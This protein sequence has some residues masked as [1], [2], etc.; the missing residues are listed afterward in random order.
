MATYYS[1]VWGCKPQIDGNST[2]SALICGR[3]VIP[4][5][6]AVATG[7][8]LLLSKLRAG[9][10]ILAFHGESNAWGDAV[11]G[12]LGHT[13]A[14]GGTNVQD[15]DSVIADVDLEDADVF[16][17]FATPLTGPFGALAED[18]VL[19]VVVGTVT[20]GT[21]A[22]EKYVNFAFQVASFG[23][24]ANVVYNWNGEASGISTTV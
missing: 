14:D 11:P 10:T 13:D 5:G 24:S 12:T 9:T 8:V 2:G 6:T 23:N 7:D 1:N 19:K 22:G 18:A 4:A 3:V 17:N 20:N 21:A 16:F 15:L